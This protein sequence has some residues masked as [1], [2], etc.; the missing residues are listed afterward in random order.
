MSKRREIEMT[1]R[2]K[3]PETRSAYSIYR[4]WRQVHFKAEYETSLLEEDDDKEIDRIV[5]VAEAT[6]RELEDELVQASISTGDDLAAVL[7]IAA[8]LLEEGAYA[9]DRA[10]RLIRIARKA[11]F[12]VGDAASVRAA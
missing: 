10:A 9:D 11:A 12:H 1:V 2:A 6:K 4:E 7:G 5:S 3:C 8:R